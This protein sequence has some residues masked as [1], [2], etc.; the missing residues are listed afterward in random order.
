[1][2]LSTL[3]RSRMTSLPPLLFAPI[4]KALPWGGRKLTTLLTKSLPDEVPCGESWEVVDLPDD[5][6]AVADGPLRG[7]T[8]TDLVRDRPQELLGQSQLLMGRFPVLFKFIDARTTLSVQV[9]PDERACA[10]LGGGA[11]PKTEAWFILQADPDARLYLGLERDVGPAELRAA[12]DSGTV[13]DLLV[14]V[15]VAPGDFF[16]LPAGLLHA[17][18][19]GIVLAEVQQAS[20]TTYRVFDWNRVGLDGK[21]RQLHVDQALASINFEL[22][23]RCVGTNPVTTESA[24]DSE[25]GDVSPQSLKKS[26]IPKG[27]SCESFSF[28]SFELEEGAAIHL[29]GNRPVIASCVE[30]NVQVNAPGGT[31]TL[32]LGRTCLVPLQDGQISLESD[33]QSNVLLV[34]Y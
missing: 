2:E 18:G 19:G 9:H 6:S 14:A 34:E 21:P 10:T 16:Y 30:G 3:H 17:I 31:V 22:R 25:I 24:E 13:A 28:V 20:D 1:M 11:R 23:G 32:G 5:R 7:A 8:L 33:D 12:I 15:D 27:V 29:P 4:V 26:A